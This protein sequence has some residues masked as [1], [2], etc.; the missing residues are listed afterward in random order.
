[1]TDENVI[2]IILGAVVCQQIMNMVG[3]LTVLWVRAVALD[4]LIEITPRD[5]PQRSHSVVL[6]IE[7]GLIGL[8]VS[9]LQ[10]P[11]TSR[12]A[13][14][15]DPRRILIGQISST[16]FQT[17][18]TNLTAVN[19]QC[20]PREMSAGPYPLDPYLLR[21]WNFRTAQNGSLITADL[22]VRL[23]HLLVPKNYPQDHEV[24]DCRDLRSMALT[25]VTRNLVL[26]FLSD[27]LDN[28]T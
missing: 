14:E 2:Q 4:A 28:P 3:R 18:L 15:P 9:A 25:H 23:S 17:G 5:R 21:D 26:T 6:H 11:V 13:H 19:R 10:T 16:I 27:G 20:V 7:T 24:A 8:A 12:L 22:L 1:M